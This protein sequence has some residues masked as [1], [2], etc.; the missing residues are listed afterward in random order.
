MFT[1]IARAASTA[2]MVALLTGCSTV[3]PTTE[4]RDE[5]LQKAEAE[6]QEWKKVDPDMEAFVQ[7]RYGFAFFPEITKGGAGIGG[8]YGRGVVFEQGQHVGYADLTEGSFGLQ[9]GGQKYSELI[10]FQDKFAFDRFKRN[11]MDFGANA[12]AIMATSG[13]S[14]NA[15]FTD[16]IA[17]FVRPLSG[18]M[19]EATISGQR[20]TYA[21]K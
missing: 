11:P 12:S 1:T 15:P 3:P 7:K 5:L 17:V 10:V 4:E 21:P 16:G 6:R 20:L 19:A 13:A 18:A 14:T 8:G 9:L 2:L